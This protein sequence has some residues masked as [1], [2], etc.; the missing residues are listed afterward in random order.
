MPFVYP[1]VSATIHL[2]SKKKWAYTS[3][4]MQ[5][6][7]DE[8]AFLK[9]YD[10]YATAV[11]RYVYFRVFNHERAQDYTQEIFT[12]TWQYLIEGKEVKNLRAFLYQVA[13]NLII[14]ESRKKQSLSLDELHDEQGFDPG[15]DGRQELDIQIDARDAVKILGRLDV[16]H[17]EVLVLRYVS[18]CKPKE[19]AE[20]LGETDNVISVRIHRAKAQIKKFLK[21]QKDTQS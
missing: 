21:P 15:F 16:K 8:K 19:I 11:F 3:S 1:V 17:R 5:H 4:S 10:Q 7:V 9:A 14:D 6:M 18:G 12:R 13:R 2:S 20:I